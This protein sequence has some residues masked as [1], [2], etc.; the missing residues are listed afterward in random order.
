MTE[1]TSPHGKRMPILVLRLV[2]L[3]VLVAALTMHM[4]SVRVFR[5]EQSVSGGILVTYC[6]VS[7]GLTLCAGTENCGGQALQAFLCGAGA[8]IFAVNATVIWRRWRRASEL[9]RVVAELLFAMGVPLK[10]HV[11]IKVFLS[12]IA[13]AALLLDLALAPLLGQALAT[14]NT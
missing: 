13:A 8:A 2:T 1:F 10:R 9:T 6:V 11:R 4:R 5:W 14:V 3:A 12:G 7:L